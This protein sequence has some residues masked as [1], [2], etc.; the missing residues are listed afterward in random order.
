MKAQA[1]TL[2]L[3][4]VCFSVLSNA[5][6]I[7]YPYQELD[8]GKVVIHK[9][10]IYGKDDPASQVL[11][12]FILKSK[13]PGPILVQINSGGWRS[14]PVRIPNGKE[15]DFIKRLKPHFDAG[16]SIAIVSHRSVDR[17]DV[18]WPAPMDDVARAVQYLR[19]KAE[20]WH[21]DPNRISLSGRSSGSHLAEM[22][23]YSP[24]RANL[25]DPDPVARQSTV[26]TCVIA[27]AG[28]SDLSHH[29]RMCLQTGPGT[30]PAMSKG[31]AALKLKE[32]FGLGPQAV[33]TSEMDERLRAMSPLF[34]LKRDSTPTLLVHS[35]P[36]DAASQND[37]RLS[38]NI[39]TPINGFIMAERM[40][41][42]GIPHRFVLKGRQDPDRVKREIQ[43]LNKYN[44]ID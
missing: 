32:L 13:S 25:Q 39:H 22:V 40:K 37:P 8:V 44:K 38:W 36:P 16:Y 29:F 24:D 33:G 5:S 28:T 10:A 2:H 12:A 6:S 11:N 30:K 1:I 7:E 41:E 20:D 19:S 31:Y 3:L 26:I 34:L 42:L 43:F 4:L 35:G 14:K 17:D 23:A 15:K 9:N 18:L 27:Y 21:I